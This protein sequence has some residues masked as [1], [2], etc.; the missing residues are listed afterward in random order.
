V[1]VWP[2]SWHG[3]SSD[4]KFPMLCSEMP[5]DIPMHFLQR[6][7]RALESFPPCNLSSA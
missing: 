5:E 7:K 2:E 3:E 6:L 1:D 4:D